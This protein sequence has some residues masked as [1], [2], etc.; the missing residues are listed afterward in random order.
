VR[1]AAPAKPEPDLPSPFD[2]D[3]DPDG[4]DDAP[5]SSTTRTPTGTRP[6]QPAVPTDPALQRNL[7]RITRADQC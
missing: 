3:R 7:R 4:A 5:F 2:R 6:P 1:A